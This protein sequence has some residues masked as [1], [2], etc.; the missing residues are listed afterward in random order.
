MATPTTPHVISLANCV[1]ASTAHDE[2]E[3]EKNRLISIAMPITIMPRPLDPQTTPTTPHVTSIINY[4]LE[5]ITHDE[6]EI[7]KKDCFV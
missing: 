6:S 2:S 3:I 7:E 4:L 1:L 5:S